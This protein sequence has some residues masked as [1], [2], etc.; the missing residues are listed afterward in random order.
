MVYFKFVN[1]EMK[2]SE[3]KKRSCVDRIISLFLRSFLPMANPDFDRLYKFVNIW[4]IE[5][6]NFEHY[7]LREVGLDINNYVIVKAPFKN[8]FGYW[9]DSN[10]TEKSFASHF[11]IEYINKD[12]FENVWKEGIGKGIDRTGS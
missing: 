3:N 8:N 6:D 10:M 9:T 1:N 11:N 12:D 2:G 5:Y 4:Y 7:T